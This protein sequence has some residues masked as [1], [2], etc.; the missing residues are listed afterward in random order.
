M[1]KCHT[2]RHTSGTSA[3][4][5]SDVHMLAHWKGTSA[6]YGSRQTLYN[7][8]QSLLVQRLGNLWLLTVKRNTTTHK[9][10]KQGH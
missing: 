5:S 2:V 9:V 7:P 6:A 4:C 10:H 1:Y 3:F 8:V